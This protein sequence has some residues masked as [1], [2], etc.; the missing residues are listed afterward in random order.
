MD[1]VL[2]LLNLSFIRVTL[3]PLPYV[4]FAQH[5]R[6]G[7]DFSASPLSPAKRAVKSSL[8]LRCAGLEVFK[9]RSHSGNASGDIKAPEVMALGVKVICVSG[10]HAFDFT[11]DHGV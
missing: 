10:A 5:L 3:K 9:M 2:L 7:R 8:R 4:K 6:G 1:G 11:Q